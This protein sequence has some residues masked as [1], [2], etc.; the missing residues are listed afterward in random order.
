MSVQDNT[1]TL[2]YFRLKRVYPFFKNLFMLYCSKANRFCPPVYSE[3]LWNKQYRVLVAERNL[4]RFLQTKHC[5]WFFLCSNNR[6]TSC[7]RWSLPPIASTVWLF[8]A[9]LVSHVVSLFLFIAFLT[10]PCL[11]LFLWLS[12]FPLNQVVIKWLLNLCTVFPLFFRHSTTAVL[13]LV[14]VDTI[15]GFA[16]LWLPLSSS[17]SPAGAECL[18]KS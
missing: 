15:S 12:V 9:G 16:E 18:D 4:H 6:F 2:Q 3:I 14:S 10:F 11:Q 1:Q 5:I 17:Y 8:A 7:T 13:P